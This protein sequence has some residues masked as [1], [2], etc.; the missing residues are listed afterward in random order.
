[1]DKEEETKRKSNLPEHCIG[2]F[3]NPEVQAK[4]LEGRL[5]YYAKQKAKKEA[6]KD[7]FT[8]SKA[9]DPHAQAQLI[10]KLWGWALGSDAKE[11]MFAMKMLSDMGVTKQPAEKP[12]EEVKVDEKLNPK[13]DIAFLK[14]SINKES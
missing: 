12:E 10:D 8:L 3:K 6:V 13:E 5:K 4:A 7:G 9:S 11:A 1:M 2:Q 14:R